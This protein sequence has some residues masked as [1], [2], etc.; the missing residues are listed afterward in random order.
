MFAILSKRLTLRGFIVTDFAVQHGEF[1]AQMSRWVRE[2]RMKYKED[3]VE[4]LDHAVEAF[5][6]LLHGKNFGKTAVH[7]G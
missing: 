3:I 7:V 5:V 1:Y 2:G 4:G 6:G